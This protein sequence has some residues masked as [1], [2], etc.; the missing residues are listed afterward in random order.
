MWTIDPR[1][2]VKNGVGVV[3][4]MVESVGH[5]SVRPARDWSSVGV[6]VEQLRYRGHRFGPVRRYIL[7]HRS[8]ALSF[9]D[10]SGSNSTQYPRSGTLLTHTDNIPEAVHCPFTWSTTSPNSGAL[11]LSHRSE[12]EQYKNTSYY[13]G[14]QVVESQAQ[15]MS[16]Y[17][18]GLNMHGHIHAWRIH[19]WSHTPSTPTKSHRLA[20]G[21]CKLPHPKVQKILGYFLQREASVTCGA[22]T[23]TPSCVTG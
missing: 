3:P 15:C 9:C 4:A 1:S 7:Q 2:H 17:M 10:G 13:E 11:L 16:T 6:M 18:H 8:Q 22:T 12:T 20:V 23:P 21:L 5:S 14:P 19:A